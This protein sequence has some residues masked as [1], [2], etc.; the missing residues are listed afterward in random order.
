VMLLAEVRAVHPP[1][2]RV[3]ESIEGR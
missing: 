3:Q 1:W 2:W